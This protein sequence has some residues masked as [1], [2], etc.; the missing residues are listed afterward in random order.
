MAACSEQVAAGLVQAGL[1]V[2]DA[3]LEVTLAV[4]AVPYL[5][6]RYPHKDNK[7]IVFNHICVG[8]VGT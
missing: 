5:W 1:V 7:F 8:I 3:V 6:L 2:G 4:A